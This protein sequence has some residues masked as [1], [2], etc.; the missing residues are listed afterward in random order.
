MRTT[1]NTDEFLRSSIAQGFRFSLIDKNFHIYYNRSEITY[2][3]LSRLT[4]RTQF[5]WVFPNTDDDFI[6]LLQDATKKTQSIDR[7]NTYT[8]PATSFI[9]D[10]TNDDNQA[11]QQLI[12][13][14]GF[15]ATAIKPRDLQ[16]YG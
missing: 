9:C 2:K 16:I 10:D 6:Q 14:T 5:A 15:I 13:I 8:I 12:T 7:D 3:D 11:Q 4:E 1:N